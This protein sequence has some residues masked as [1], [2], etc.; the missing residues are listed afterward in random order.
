MDC[1]DD[2]IYGE[3]IDWPSVEAQERA[4]IRREREEE[5]YLLEVERNLL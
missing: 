1:E 3:D 5:N 4:E 2:T